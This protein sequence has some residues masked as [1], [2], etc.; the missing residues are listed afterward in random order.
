VIQKQARRLQGVFLASD[1]AATCAALLAA[2]AIR[3]E[4][5]W[6]VPLGVQPLGNYASLLP[7]IAVLWPVVF[8]FHRLY[9]LRRDRSTIDEAL[10]IV[11]AA[12]LATLL[13][14]GF[15]S[16]QRAW[17]FNRALLILFLLLDVLF[18]SLGRLAIW[19]YLEK[20][21]SA[22]VGVRRALVVGAGNAGRAI[23]DKLLDHPALGLKPVGFADDDAGKRAEP[24]RGL[25]VLGTTAEVRALLAAHEVDTIF[26]AL[27]VDAYRTMLG[28]LKD[29]GNEMVDIRFVPDL[30]QFVTFK[31]G[32]EDFDGLPVINLTQRPLEGWNSLV[33]R[34]MD[35]VLAACGL[36]V[37]AVMLPF[38]ALAIWLEDRGPVFYTQ[39]RMGLDGRLFRILKFRSMRVGAEDATGAVWATEGDARRTRVGAFLRSTSLDEVPQLVNILMGDMSLVGPRPERPEFV[40]EFKE[41]FPQYMLRH[42]VKAGLT[43]WAQVHGW[44][45]NTSL[46]K[47]IEYDLYY[48]ENWSL[49]LDLQ[50]LW[51]T[52]TRSFRDENAY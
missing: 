48:I 44:R 51:R 40:R 17:S 46:Q 13:L 20:V 14:V 3:F 16:F 26:L 27:P 2:W 42:R 5:V 35:I 30:F 45:G 36:V 11:M 33:K 24:Y 10:A 7:V 23:A 15:L 43:G 37:L 21:W 9:Q 47:R 52:A 6:P 39:E 38:I 49:G 25:E 34:T 19:R 29:V 8:Y 1:V 31:A 18:V 12:S 41:K 50:I 28:I 32:V 4:T 22:G